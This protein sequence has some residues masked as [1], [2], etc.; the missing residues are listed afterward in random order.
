MP[1]VDAVIIPYDCGSDGIRLI[2]TIFSFQV[3]PHAIE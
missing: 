2:V 3:F 1:G